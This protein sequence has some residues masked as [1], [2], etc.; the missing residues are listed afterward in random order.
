V[1]A[2]GQTWTLSSYVK[3]IAQPL[4]PNLIRVQM[5]ELTSAGGFVTFGF[6]N[7]TPT[8]TLQRYSFTR[9]LNGGATVARVQPMFDF[10]TTTGQAYDFTIRIGMPQMEQQSVATS[11]IPTTTAAVTRNA[12]VI[13]NTNAATLIGQAEGTIFVDYNKVL[14]N[15]TP[16]NIIGI[17]DG[18][19][20]NL[21]EIWDGVG[22]G[23]LG[24]L[25]YTCNTN[26]IFKSAGFGQTTISPSGR[27][28]I[29]LT[30]SFT[31]TNMNFKFFVNGVKIRDDNPTFTAFSNPL[32]RVNIGNRNGTFVG[33]GGHN[34]DFISKTAITETQAIQLTTL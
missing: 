9:T 6:Q 25:V 12:D 5:F 33:V 14:A 20:N 27:Y 29:C 28:K 34:I 16:R 31:P 30:Y 4:P 26:A 11:I 2:T 13:T 24:M 17:T 15:D 18:T 21:I 10:V 23:N 22:V 32:S 3:I 8:T 7:I 19:T 1:A